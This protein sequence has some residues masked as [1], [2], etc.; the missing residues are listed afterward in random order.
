MVTS[1]RRASTD[2]ADL[3]RLEV[4]SGLVLVTE[5]PRRSRLPTELSLPQTIVMFVMFVLIIV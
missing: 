5:T 3:T 1:G 4:D 2:L